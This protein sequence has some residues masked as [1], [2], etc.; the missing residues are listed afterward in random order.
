MLSYILENLWK[1]KDYHRSTNEQE[2]RPNDEH[3]VYLYNQSPGSSSSGSRG[4]ACVSVSLTDRDGKL[5]KCID[6]KR[7]WNF[8]F[9]L[10]I[11]ELNTFIDTQEVVEG[12]IHLYL[13]GI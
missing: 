3:N 13:K 12:M 2:H 11:S 10:S 9:S 5:I 1:F 7:P 6:W 4:V 8:Q